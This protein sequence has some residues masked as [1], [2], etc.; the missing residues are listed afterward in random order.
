MKYLNLETFT[1]FVCTGD[2][3]NFTCCGGGWEI[4][5][6]D[7]T[8]E[9]YR[10]V[11][12]EMGSRLKKSIR[13]EN[14]KNT[15][16]LNEHGDCPFLN[17]RGLCDIYIS[18][19]E[20]HLSNTCTFYPRYTFYSGDICFAGVSISCPEVAKEFL[21]HTE[22]LLID[23]AEDDQ[24]LST[25][26]EL[27]TDWNM[28]NN[29]V[30]VLTNLVNIAQNRELS[31]RERLALIIIFTHSFQDHTDNG[32]DPSSLIKLFSLPDDYIKLL[33][34]AGL[35]NRDFSSKLSF[36]SEFLTAYRQI[37][38]FEER[39]PEISELVDYYSTSENASF[40]PTKWTK[41]MEWLTG[42]DKRIWQENLLVY[43]IFRYYMQG[44]AERDFYDKLMIGINAVYNVCIYDLALYHIM[45][46]SKPGSNDYI[47]ML[48]SH[49]S[50]M[51]EHCSSFKQDV[52]NHFKNKGMNEMAFLLQL[53]S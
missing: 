7:Q 18:L 32:Q 12:G 52:F 49:I 29:A 33:P 16:I 6:D 44:F 35:N 41:A 51:V 2:K 17:E 27:S 15:F 28:F 11:T 9:Y 43:V 50:R 23:F 20:E 38:R 31:I 19:G 14:G 22:P 37:D 10:S 47:I 42:D 21:A 46:G 40:D 53:I 4:I 3:C 39:L 48:I 24:R 13:R 1:D 34:Q 30:R 8:D 26:Q 25:E 5:I 45:N 36:C